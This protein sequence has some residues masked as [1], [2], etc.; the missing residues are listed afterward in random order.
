MPR[1]CRPRR[2]TNAGHTR[3]R[4]SRPTQE[5]KKARSFRKFTYR[6]VDLDQLLDL[7]TDELVQLFSARSRRWCGAG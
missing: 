3:R 5:V 1:P 6:G 4:L 7:G 2:A